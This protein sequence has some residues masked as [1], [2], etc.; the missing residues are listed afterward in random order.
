MTKAEMIE[1]IAKDTDISK[2]AAAKAYD[3]FIDGIKSGL[4][5][6][7]SKVTVFGFGTFKKVYRKTRKGRNPQNRQEYPETK[8][9]P[10]WYP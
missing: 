1:K 6:R 9:Y 2:A 8:N 5:K 7:G 3:S 10:A 4:K